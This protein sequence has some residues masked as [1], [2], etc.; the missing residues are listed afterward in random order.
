MGA[1]QADLSLLREFAIYESLHLTVRRGAF[2]TFNRSSFG[3]PQKRP[4][5]R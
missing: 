5:C 1:I 4:E 3:Y 2:N